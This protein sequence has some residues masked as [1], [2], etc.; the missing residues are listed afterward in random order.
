MTKEISAS[1][2]RRRSVFVATPMYDGMC[3]LTYH[4]S[5]LATLFET[6]KYGVKMMPY[7]MGNESLIQR[8]RNYCAAAFMDSG[9]THLLFIDGDI[10]WQPDAVLNLLT[11]ADPQSDYDVICAPYPKKHITPEKIIN[12]VQKGL[13]K[14]ET[15]LYDYIGDFAFNVKHET[16]DIQLDRPFPITEGGTGFMLIQ[17]KAIEKIIDRFPEIMYRPD[18]KRD[19]QF[20]GT[21]KIPALFDCEIDRGTFNAD[22]WTVIRSVANDEPDAKDR[23]KAIVERSKTASERYLSEDY[24]FSRYALAAGCGVWM[25]PWIRLAHVGR[26]VFG[27]SLPHM[28]MSGESPTIGNK[29]QLQQISADQ[30]MVTT[31]F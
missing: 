20:D 18:H 9:F 22:L 14:K 10:E 7:T 4:Q 6:S 12:A 1:E 8:A 30:P 3:M 28:L 23:C 16:T 2:L 25:A 27:G 11:W 5:Y 24:Q 19:A 29:P 21:R 26:F 15:D 17:R 31:P 13:I